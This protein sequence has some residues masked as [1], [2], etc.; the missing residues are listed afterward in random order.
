MQMQLPMQ[1]T[2]NINDYPM[3]MPIANEVDSS[4]LAYGYSQFAATPDRKSSASMSFSESQS[5][6][7]VHDYR[8]PAP[9]YMMEPH[10]QM[11]QPRPRPQTAP[12]HSA[13]AFTFTDTQLQ[14]KREHQSHQD[15]NSST[16][17]NP[18]STNESANQF[19]QPSIAS[20]ESLQPLQPPHA[21][22][23]PHHYDQFQ[24]IAPLTSATAMTPTPS[25]CAPSP[26]ATS[27]M[28]NLQINVQSI[29]QPR[30]IK[31]K[32]YRPL[33]D[34]HMM[35][36]FSEQP[37]QNQPI[38]LPA[39][40]SPSPILPYRVQNYSEPAHSLLDAPVM[41]NASWTTMPS[42]LSSLSNLPEQSP[43]YTMFDAASQ[44]H[45]VQPNH[46]PRPARLRNPNSLA[47]APAPAQSTPT[48]ASSPGRVVTWKTYV[49]HIVFHEH[50]R[51]HQLYEKFAKLGVGVFA[52]VYKTARKNPARPVALKVFPKKS[53][54]SE[55][56]FANELMLLHNVS[57]PNI[58][59][60][61][62]AHVDP[63]YFY[64]EMELC[65]GGDLFKHISQGGA[66]TEEMSRP[67]VFKILDVIRCLHEKDFVH[68]D[69]KPEN[70]V[71]VRRRDFSNIRLIDF[72]AAIHVDPQGSYDEYVGTPCYFAPERFRRHSGAELKKADVWAIGVIA[73]ETLTGCRC[74]NGGKDSDAVRD[75]VVKKNMEPWPQHVNVSDAAKDFVN[76]LLEMNPLKRYSCEE[77]LR[78]PWLAQELHEHQMQNANGSGLD[79][80]AQPKLM[81]LDDATV[82][83]S[84]EM[85]P[86]S[87]VIKTSQSMSDLK[88]GFH[89]AWE[90]R[91][92]LKKKL[93][94]KYND[95]GHSKSAENPTSTSA[96]KRASEYSAPRSH[97]H[98][99]DCE[100][101]EPIPTHPFQVRVSRMHSRSMDD[102]EE[103]MADTLSPLMSTL[104]LPKKQKPSVGPKL[105][106]NTLGNPNERTSAM[107]IGK[108]MAVDVPPQPQSQW[109]CAVQPPLMGPG[110][111]RHQKSHS[112]PSMATPA[113]LPEDSTVSSSSKEDEWRTHTVSKTYTASN[114]G[115]GLQSQ[116]SN[117]F[118]P[119]Q[120]SNTSSLSLS[121]HGHPYAPT[122][123]HEMKHVAHSVSG[124]FS[125]QTFSGVRDVLEDEIMD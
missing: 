21:T 105:R 59:R 13:P 112:S 36:R 5:G 50:A 78:H 103:Q 22:A 49:G 113:M 99:D 53:S 116:I 70:L 92:T 85:A 63:K 28:G 52:R 8:S 101:S 60:F 82:A 86:Q 16:N 95:I 84:Q 26:S 4:Q 104:S 10:H 25:P 48:R 118:T 2:Q 123:S 6:A 91:Q 20:T 30:F 115:S 14:H 15:S 61:Y 12:I 38:Q 75:N 32:R 42:N 120:I 17:P 117:T 19:Q 119:T 110:P 87:I 7:Y 71:F 74:F 27:G 124:S 43:Q 79:N 109:T 100:P 83:R 45:Q 23:S 102:S 44:S 56:S 108:S 33:N 67:I 47:A 35:Q 54:C 90:H 34:Q 96:F 9:L 111:L 46:R 69:L 88:S 29:G 77:A 97:A 41:S 11:Q 58:V 3:Q 98:T 80:S 1:D 18:S 107:L 57:H 76:C 39:H 125:I 65:N 81:A 40:H 89:E 66:F 122:S 37:M 93:A 24:Q 73:F 106:S 94:R 68:R 121:S 114:C 51:G 31:P 62:D 72:G 64:L 55:G